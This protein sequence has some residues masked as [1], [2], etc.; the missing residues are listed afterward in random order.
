MKNRFTYAFLLFF[1]AVAVF[2]TEQFVHKIKPSVTTIP[3]VALNGSGP[4]SQGGPDY[5]N[6]LVLVGHSSNVFVGKV[7][8]M[9]GTKPP[10][11]IS[12][13]S[14]SQYAVDVILNIKGN[15][16]GDVVVNQFEFGHL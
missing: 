12:T 3:D 2:G 15:L 10:D 8:S 11:D 4:Y 16:R 1:I 13:R 5:S 6:S 9:T 7:L 14:S